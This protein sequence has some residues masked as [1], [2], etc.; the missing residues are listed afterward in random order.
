MRPISEK[1][2]QLIEYISDEMSASE[3][4]AFEIQ[5][6]KNP[7]LQKEVEDLR[8]AKFAL[9]K[10]KDEKIIPPSIDSLIRTPP[11]SGYKASAVTITPWLKIAA[12]ILFFFVCAWLF[13]VEL[14]QVEN[15]LTL[16][17]GGE[18]GH[19]RSVQSLAK[20]GTNSSTTE[21]DKQE[22]I[23]EILD[24]MT[25]TQDRFLNNWSNEFIA[26]LEDILAEREN[27]QSANIEEIVTRIQNEEVDKRH[28]ELTSLMNLWESRRQEDLQNIELAFSR[29]AEALSKQQYETEELLTSIFYTTP[30]KNY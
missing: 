5:L 26:S 9:L 19:S 25:S 24:T 10:W 6:H 13:N 20:E 15:G 7:E 29:I 2:R 27:R 30:A 3:K 4:A 18:R 23:S 8:N 12:S 11:E 17:F 28:D 21:I 22:I 14:T 1:E 16:R